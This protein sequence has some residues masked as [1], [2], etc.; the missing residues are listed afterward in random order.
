MRT[1]TNNCKMKTLA[2][3]RNNAFYMPHL[4]LRILVAQP[5]VAL[6]ATK[7]Q[8]LSYI[9]YRIRNLQSLS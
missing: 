8:M 5:D 4:G 2:S 6:Q 7:Y 3:F 1:N 9:I